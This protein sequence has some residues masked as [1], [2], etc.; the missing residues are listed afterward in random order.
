MP[1]AWFSSKSIGIPYQA[2]H[3]DVSPSNETETL[4]L[5]QHMFNVSN[6][7]RRMANHFGLKQGQMLKVLETANAFRLHEVSSIAFSEEQQR[8]LKGTRTKADIQQLVRDAIAEVLSHDEKLRHLVFDY[9][10]DP[11]SCVEF[12]IVWYADK[13]HQVL[14]LLG[15]LHRGNRFVISHLVRE[16]EKLIDRHKE[17]CDRYSKYDWTSLHAYVLEE[18]EEK[19]RSFTLDPDEPETERLQTLLASLAEEGEDDGS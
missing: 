14:F 4:P 17:L 2:R 19:T 9:H 10:D 7:S 6:L 5:S 8:K 15:Q 12:S 13:V 1:K 3:V 18:V 16:L 11:L